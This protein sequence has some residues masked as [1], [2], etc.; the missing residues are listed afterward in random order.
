MSPWIQQYLISSG[1][2]VTR[3]IALCFYTSLG[4]SSYNWQAKRTGQ[5]RAGNGK[6]DS[7]NPKP[8]S[9]C[10]SQSVGAGQGVQLV[11]S[12]IFCCWDDTTDWVICTE[13]YFSQPGVREVQY[14]IGCKY[15]SPASG[16]GLL[17]R[18]QGI[19]G[20]TQVSLLPT[21]GVP[22]PM[23]SGNPTHFPKAPTSKSHQHMTWGVQFPTCGLWGDTAKPQQRGEGASSPM[24]AAA[25]Q[26]TSESACSVDHKA[27]GGQVSQGGTWAGA[28]RQRKLRPIQG[29]H[30]RVWLEDTILRGD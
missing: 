6:S 20:K 14:Q 5:C 29:P 16:E 9:I 21:R 11:S 23:I 22:I 10:P 19:L 4:W 12:F 30:S 18:T 28:R 13:I 2:S 26:Q 7:R 1:F 27:K 24:S 3:T 15:E 17:A 25:S 8:G